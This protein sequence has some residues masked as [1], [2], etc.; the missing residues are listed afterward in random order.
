MKKIL[1]FALAA[2]A[3]ASCSN[4]SEKAS[5][6]SL[7]IQDSISQ[8]DTAILPATDS[9]TDTLS[10]QPAQT[11]EESFADLLPDPKKIMDNL[12]RVK[13]TKYLESLGFTGTAKKLVNQKGFAEGSAGDFELKKGEKECEVEWEEGEA[14]DSGCYLCTVTVEI[15]GD[16]DALNAFYKKASSLKKQD[17]DYSCTVSKKGNKVIIEAS[18]C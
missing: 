17:V 10:Q 2:L 6:D 14:D 5:D 13:E 9:V 15:T 8:T 16:A 11:A 1:Y 18:G 7:Q 12:E 4:K 3:F